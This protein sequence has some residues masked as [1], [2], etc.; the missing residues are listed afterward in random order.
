VD[1]AQFLTL[2]LADEVQRREQQALERHLLRRIRDALWT[3]LIGRPLSN[4]RQL[5]HVF[6]LQF[7]GAR[8]RL[9]VDPS[10]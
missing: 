6:T 4:R 1:Y 5:Q 3:T 2:L 8:A 7:L 10:A 9:I